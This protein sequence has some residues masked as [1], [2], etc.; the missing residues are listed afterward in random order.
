MLIVEWR[1]WTI[2]NLKSSWLT[3]LDRT[4]EHWP[5][6]SSPSLSRQTALVQ[7]SSSGLWVRDRYPASDWSLAHNSGF[8]LVNDTLSDCLWWMQ[9]TLLGRK[10]RGHRRWHPASNVD[11]Y[12]AITAD[13]VSH[14]HN[15]IEFWQSS[16]D[17]LEVI[18]ALTETGIYNI[19]NIW[20][21]RSK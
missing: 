6:S 19:Y 4:P 20:K 2:N 9:I 13:F 15:H 3:Y 12:P 16:S 18:T 1:R 8:S 10:L 14:Y 5:D 7:V 21:T 17:K 11:S